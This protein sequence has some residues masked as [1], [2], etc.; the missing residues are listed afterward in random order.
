LR[1]VETRPNPAAAS[2]SRGEQPVGMQHGLQTLGQGNR[3]RDGGRGEDEAA[4]AGLVE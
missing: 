3:E 4:P 1:P 2:R